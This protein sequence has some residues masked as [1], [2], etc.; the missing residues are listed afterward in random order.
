M[1]DMSKLMSR[2]ATL[3]VGG[4][5]LLLLGAAGGGAV[6]HMARPAVEMAP[7]NAVAIASLAQRTGIVTV[8]G[9]VA[10]VYG[11]RFV[12]V[13]GSGRTMVD[14]GRAGRDVQSG[15]PVTVQGHYDNGQLRASFMVDRNG[16]V[17]PVGPRFGRRFEH[18]GS[19]GR[20]GPE[21]REDRD[22]R[23]GADRGG[24]P[25]PPGCGPAGPGMAPPQPVTPGK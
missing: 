17:E 20:D 16:T 2:R 9:K 7:A 11:D 15:A 12:I 25:P 10:E 19:E 24:P 22:G 23:F 13:D 8:K 21:G 18:R 14:A 4:A 1:V 6:A 3:G 5:G